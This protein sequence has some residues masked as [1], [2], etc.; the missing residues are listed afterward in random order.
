MTDSDA[1]DGYSGRKHQMEQVEVVRRSIEALNAVCERPGPGESRESQP[2]EHVWP[3]QSLDA[4]R[5]FG[6][7][8]AKLFPFI[9]RKVRTP[10]G[11]GTLIQVFAEKVTVVLDSE[12]S[13]CSFFYPG[14]VEP[15]SWEL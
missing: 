1:S 7:P 4:E 2:S 8:H 5:R 10:V 14:E 13:G 12:V 11:A 15:V 9:G 3:A 6:R